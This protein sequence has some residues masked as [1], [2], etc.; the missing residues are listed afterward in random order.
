MSDEYERTLSPTEQDLAHQLSELSLNEEVSATKFPFSMS[1]TDDVLSGKSAVSNMP[2]QTEVNLL[3]NKFR[4]SQFPSLGDQ[5]QNRR[6]NT[7]LFK[8][9]ICNMW[10]EL[11]YCRYGEECCF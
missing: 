10:K 3:Q 9:K 7:H 1:N 8:T 4:K 6:H 11:G 2:G 5:R